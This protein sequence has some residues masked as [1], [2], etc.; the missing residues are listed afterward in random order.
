MLLQIQ[1]AHRAQQ[2]HLIGNHVEGATAVHL[3][4]TDDHRLQSIQAASDRLLQLRD[5][6]GGKPNSIHRLM[7]AGT[8]PPFPLHHDLQ[9]AG[10]RGETAP[11]DPD[12]AHRQIWHHMEPIQGSKAIYSPRIPH[13]HRPLGQLFSGL[14]QQPHPTAQLRLLG[15]QPRH[16]QACAGVQIMA[17]GMHQALAGGGIGQ[18]GAFLHRKS[19]HVDPQPHRGP[20]LRPQLGHHTRATNPLAHAPT[21]LT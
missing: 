19:I 14:K 12:R 2:A 15:Q 17:A 13:P 10:R 4:E 11:S 21:Q 6:A 8:M 7:G 5:H 20:L 9:H 16:P 18:A 3:A 1:A